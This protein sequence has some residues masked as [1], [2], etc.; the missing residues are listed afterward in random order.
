VSNTTGDI[1]VWNNGR[2]K[3][4]LSADSAGTGGDSITKIVERYRTGGAVPTVEVDQSSFNVNNYY[5]VNTD[6]DYGSVPPGLQPFTVVAIHKPIG[7]GAGD[8]STDPRVYSKDS[9]FHTDEHDLMLGYVTGSTYTYFRMRIRWNGITTTCVPTEVAAK[10]IENDAWNLIAGTWEPGGT[11]T[12][13][14]QV[15]HFNDANGF[16]A[17]GAQV[18]TT[19]TGYDPRTSTYEGLYNTVGTPG[20]EDRNPYQGSIACVLFFEGIEIQEEQ[21]YR[22]LFDNPWQVFQPQRIIVPT[23]PYVPTDEAPAPAGATKTASGTPDAPLLT[24]AG[25]ALRTS[26]KITD[27]AN[28]GETPGLGSETWSDGS[29]GNVITGT[30]FL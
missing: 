12:A 2:L 27:V 6:A 7:D 5:F 23:F 16:Q 10:A 15:Y 1:P 4:Y 13:T 22:S 20:T 11:G 3:K 29:S 19:G 28:S 26:V 8:S 9:G 21:D 25:T 24:A 17:G 18:R 14:A 30:G